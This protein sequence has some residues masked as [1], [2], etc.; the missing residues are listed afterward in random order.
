MPADIAGPPGKSKGIRK[1]RGEGLG[2]KKAR[3]SVTKWSMSISRSAEGLKSC[4]TPS[5]RL[6]S[7]RADPRESLPYVEGGDSHL[8]AFCP[9]CRHITIAVGQHGPF[10]TH[11]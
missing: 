1:D 5:S 8:L 2:G 7:Q 11:Y 4:Y 3:R 6:V 9:V 10:I